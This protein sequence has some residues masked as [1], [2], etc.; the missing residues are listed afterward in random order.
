MIPAKL[1]RGKGG[2]SDFGGWRIDLVGASHSRGLIGVFVVLALCWA[3]SEDRRRF[4]VVL[5]AGSLLVQAGLILLLF[6][7][8]VARSA[9]NGVNGAVDALGSSAQSGTSFVFG[10]LAGQ[11]PP[12]YALERPQAVFVF[13]FRVLP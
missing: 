2:K 4:P 5:A 7:A 3:I 9:L 10:Y 6:G 12:P 13:A 8:P 1:I 11:A